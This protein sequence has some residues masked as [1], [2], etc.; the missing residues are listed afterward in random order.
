M[1]DGAGRQ[2]AGSGE[3]RD[4]TMPFSRVPEV[5][6]ELARLTRDV[7]AQETLVMLL[8]QQVEQARM[9]EARDLPVVQ[10]LD[11]AVAPERPS[12]PR[13][14]LNLAVASVTSVFGGVVLAFIV[15][16]VKSLRRRPRAA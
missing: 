16:Y 6:L 7:K 10:A 4:F 3:R 14:G 12:R 13:L 5:S 15:E 9:S 2:A 11:R 1:Q 8:M